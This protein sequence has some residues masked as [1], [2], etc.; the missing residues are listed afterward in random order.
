MNQVSRFFIP[1]GS[2]GT[3]S[4]KILAIGQIVIFLA[5]WIL[6]P[7]QYIPTPDRIIAA[8]HE[9]ATK[10]GMLMELWASAFTI[11]KAILLTTF[12]S[13][14][15]GALSTL[16]FF[17]PPARWLSA[18]RFLGFAG[19]TFLLT[20]WSS[21]GSDLKLYLLTF[22]MTAFMLTNTL[23]TVRSISQRE[24]DYTRTL[25]MS[26]WRSLWELFFQGKKAEI[27][28]MV[29]QNAAIG[30]TLLSMVEGLVRSEGGI[31]AM[32]LNQNRYFNLEA[33]FA[34]QI[35]ILVYGISQDYIMQMIR[36]MLCPYVKLTEAK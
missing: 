7:N 13:V 29:R 15:F 31:G 19:V 30:W 3:S 26:P 14:G 6:V 8:W 23:S 5:I 17:E 4:M 18:V 21:N 33:V 25:S 1:F 27:L 35:T 24:I 9:L 16:R 28:D 36:T 2:V 11:L 34:I 20:L 10:Q 12:I 32:L 22:G